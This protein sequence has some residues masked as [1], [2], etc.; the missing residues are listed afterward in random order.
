MNNTDI[1]ALRR[2]LHR[3][4]ELGFVEFY[5]ASRVL[6]ALE[7]L[8][9]SVRT[10]AE[11]MNVAEIVNYPDAETREEWAARGIAAGGNPERIRYLRDHGSAVVAEITGNRPG[12]VWGLRVD[13]DALP[14]AEAADERH[15]PAREGF[16]SVTPAM[17]A[18]GHD[19]HV[20]IGVGLLH[21]LADHDFPGTVRILF[22][23]A[24][25]GVR[26]AR[27]MV[28]AGVVEGVE[29]MLAVH[30][31]HDRP[32]G[33][34]VGS[35]VDAMATTKYVLD[36]RGVAAHAAASPE[37]GRNALAAAA[38]ATLG[39]LGIPRVSSGETRVNVGTL[40]AD[41]AANIIPAAARM[42]FET[43]GTSNAAHEEIDR[44][45][46]EIVAGAASMHGVEYELRVTG[47]APNMVP[48][49]AMIDL[50][51]AAAAALPGEINFHRTI[52][53]TGS[54]DANI[55]IRAVQE[56]G[57]QGA[58]V[59]VCSGNP[60]PHHSEY[61]DVDEASILLAVDLLENLLRAG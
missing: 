23:P 44:R 11:A 25:E 4:A 10:G 34:I 12:P 48:D 1:I 38:T 28:S 35:G 6:D 40:R 42:T 39:L 54:D 43:R 55:F 52:T 53:T 22:Q 31:G 20:A 37:H 47:G 18:C 7:D 61:F 5:T 9:V 13:M 58:Y 30:L 26:G 16:R 2:D 56:A 29:R 46:K 17:H 24:E 57:G 41:G 8:P 59:Q 33:L 14:V 60:G 3:N 19:G 32:T 50:V 51:G 45:A 21:R 27:P 49:E 36:Y 15:L